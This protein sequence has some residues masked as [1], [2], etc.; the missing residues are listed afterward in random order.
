VKSLT[1]EE[2]QYLADMMERRIEGLL[3]ELHHSRTHHFEDAL[4]DEI[5]LS[6]RLREKLCGGAVGAAS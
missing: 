5:A 1:D 2:R 6:E 4:K 3:H